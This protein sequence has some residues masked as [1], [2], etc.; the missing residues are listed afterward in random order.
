MKINFI[1]LA[2]LSLLIK[3]GYSQWLDK[4][5]LEKQ[6]YSWIVSSDINVDFIDENTGMFSYSYYTTPSQGYKVDILSTGNS[7]VSW[8]Y[9]NTSFSTNSSAIHTARNQN[10]FY[11][12]VSNQFYR[13]LEKSSN[14]GL[15]WTEFQNRFIDYYGHYIDFVAIDTSHL[16]YLFNRNGC[17]C[18]NK[19]TYGIVEQKIDSFCIENPSSMYF[20]DTTTGY[21]ITSKN[22]IY[23]STSEG[24]NWIKIYSDSSL[25]MNK[26]FFISPEIG[27][28]V[29]DSGK[30]IKTTNG[31]LNWLNLNSNTELNLRSL[32]FI[33]DSIGFIAGDSGLI[34]KTTNGGINWLKQETGTTDPFSKIFFV[35][36]SIGFAQSGSYLHKTNIRSPWGVWEIVSNYKC[37]IYPNPFDIQTTIEI[38]IPLKGAILSVYN[39]F[40]EELKRLK[41]ISNN[42]ITLKRDNLDSGIYFICIRQN[43]L[44][45]MTDKIIIKD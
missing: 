22:N 8:N 29:G 18:I 6:L 24:T 38:D 12:C 33:T 11:H 30:I 25:K 42:I 36:D 27:Y 16:Y 1:L 7:G 23:K 4:I 14:R 10:T 20:P 9:V 45:L 15:T 34:I 28:L 3:V 2:I 21:I 32:H 39:C 43:G 35:N 5:Y 19:Y 17:S 31:G 37:K 44:I 26:M 40:G 41:N 13:R